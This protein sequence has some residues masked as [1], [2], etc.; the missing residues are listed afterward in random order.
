MYKI[1]CLLVGIILCL[2]AYKTYISP[3]SFGD[4]AQVAVSFIALLPDNKPKRKR[5]RKPKRG[6]K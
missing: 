2:L 6:R 3:D 1:K 5:K 4:F